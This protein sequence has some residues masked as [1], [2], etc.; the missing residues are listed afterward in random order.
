[1]RPSSRAFSLLEL[2]LVM[3]IMG[4]TTAV[5]AARLSPLRRSEGVLQG[6]H[7]LEDQLN[8]GRRLAL[9]QSELARVQLDLDAQ[10][11]TV[12]MRTADGFADAKDADLPDADLRFG[13][14]AQ[15]ISFVG[16][17]AKI[18]TNG[19]VDLLFYSD[20]RCEPSGSVT[21]QKGASLATVVCPAAGR[22]AYV[23][24]T[25]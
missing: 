21:I 7:A 1:M 12:Q 24:A 20:G 13:A 9:A 15:V 8:R 4:I 16:A 22:P 23:E 17:D 11:A 3:V 6:A 25:P 18:Q 10:T 2:I 19:L 5:A 14:E